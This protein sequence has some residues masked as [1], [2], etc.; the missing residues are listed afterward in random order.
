MITNMIKTMTHCCNE[1][2]LIFETFPCIADFHLFSYH[3]VP[4]SSQLM[5]YILIHCTDF[6]QHIGQV[7]CDTIVTV[8]Q[9]QSTNGIIAF[10]C[11]SQ[12][13]AHPTH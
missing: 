9:I 13:P 8:T 10:S 4:Y 1:H 11:R 2:L 5:I 12:F 7:F 6:T 3:S